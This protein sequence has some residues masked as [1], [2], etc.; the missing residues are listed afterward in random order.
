M[1]GD[2]SHDA[3][4]LRSVVGGVLVEMVNQLFR[5]QPAAEFLLSDH[6]VL[7]SVPTHI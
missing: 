3:D 1:L 2:R 7:I 6:A 4:V 5:F